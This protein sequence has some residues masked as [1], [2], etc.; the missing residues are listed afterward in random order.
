MRRLLVLQLI[1]P[2]ISYSETIFGNLD[3]SSLHKLN[4]AFNNAARYVYGLRQ[5]DHI[6]SYQDKLLGC[7]LEPY[8]KFRNC[9]FLYKLIHSKTPHYLCE[10]LIFCKSTRG[11]NFIV[12]LFKYLNSQ[13]CFF[14]IRLWNALPCKIK[15]ITH[16]TNFKS[17]IFDIFKIITTCYCELIF[18]FC[19]F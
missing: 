3:A 5:Y 8:I 4:V 2:I 7:H 1:V 6:F 16:M 11:N 15:E 10:K 14:A 9:I 12:P 19:S 13:R 18:K 17:A